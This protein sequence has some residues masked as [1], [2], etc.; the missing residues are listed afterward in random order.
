MDH[1]LRKQPFDIVELFPD[2]YRADIIENLQLLD[3]ADTDATFDRRE[4]PDLV[5]FLAFERRLSAGL[6]IVAQRLAELYD[7]Y[8]NLGADYLPD[9]WNP[10]SDR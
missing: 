8:W 10:C 2:Y 4:H 3:Q 1:L 7:K 5:T 9:F 6:Y